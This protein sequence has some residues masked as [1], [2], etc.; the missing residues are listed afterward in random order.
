MCGDCSTLLETPSVRSLFS[1]ARARWR[2]LICWPEKAPWYTRRSWR[3]WLGKK[4]ICSVCSHFYLE[5]ENWPKMHECV[6]L[7]QQ[8][9]AGGHCWLQKGLAAISFL[10]LALC[11]MLILAT[12]FVSSTANY[13]Q[14]VLFYYYYFFK[15]LYISDIY[16][17][18]CGRTLRE[19][20]QVS[21]KLL[22]L[23]FAIFLIEM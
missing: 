11:Q 20:D 5:M 19:L 15:Y 21:M 1:R 23:L 16:I 13:M 22:L 10:V 18:F 7:N 14:H 17:V 8:I 3:M 2:D 9:I 4:N 12:E 6:C